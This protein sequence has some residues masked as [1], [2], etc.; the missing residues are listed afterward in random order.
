MTLCKSREEVRSAF[1]ALVN[2]VNKL[3]VRN[4]EVLVQVTH[5]HTVKREDV[6]SLSTLMR[7]GGVITCVMMMMQ[8]FLDGEEYVVD[9]VS[10][11]G[12]IK[13][14]AVWHYD[15][16]PLNGQFNVYFGQEPVSLD[17]VHSHHIT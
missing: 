17:Q 10:L 3:G 11:D 1:D 7:D 14:V 16:R 5:T 4:V 2:R 6:M 8:E 13:T 15:K 12:E 9:S